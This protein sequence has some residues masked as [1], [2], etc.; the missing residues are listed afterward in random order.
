MSS[1]VLPGKFVFLHMPKTGGYWFTWEVKRQAEIVEIGK[2]AHFQHIPDE[3]RNLPVVSVARESADW[4]EGYFCYAQSR[5]WD[6]ANTMERTS[7]ADSVDQFA[8]NLMANHPYLLR[9][10]YAEYAFR[11][12]YVID[13]SRLSD[14][15]ARLFLMFGLQSPDAAKRNDTPRTAK[16]SWEVC[17]DWQTHNADVAERFGWVIPGG[18][19]FA[20]PD[21]SGWWQ[22]TCEFL[23]PMFR[24]RPCRL[25]EIGV[26]EGRSA[27]IASSLLMR[28]P[29]SEYTGVDNWMISPRHRAER[30]IAIQDRKFSLMDRFV[31]DSKLR[32]A[33]DM[34]PE[35]G[36][37]NL[38]YVDGGH[39]YEECMQDIHDC[40]SMLSVGGVM[41]IDDYGHGTTYPGVKRATDEFLAGV[42]YREIVISPDYYQKVVVKRS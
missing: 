13:F 15:A 9:D 24:G 32:Y 10:H 8:L 31:F 20:L 22:Q 23:A 3:Y 2:H 39:S 6:D 42:Q 1:F 35:N 37:F 34:V 12:D 29:E 4:L 16:L 26:C 41:V 40:W 25:L 14:E 21:W 27:L 33:K 30:N 11:A 28:H 18:L 17:R 36:E 38:V 5:G 7:K 19:I